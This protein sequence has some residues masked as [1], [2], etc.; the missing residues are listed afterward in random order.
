[1][2]K[3]LTAK[4]LTAKQEA[5]VSAYIGEAR[6]NATRA[7]TIAGYP[8]RS[9]YQRGFEL[10]RKSEVRARIDEHLE[11]LTLSAKEVLAEITDV[12]SAEWRDFLTIKRN[13]KTGEEVDVS[14][15]LGAKV[16]SLELLAKA[17]GLLTDKVQH[18]GT[19]EFLAAL[20]SFGGNSN[21]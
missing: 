12:A 17:H 5:F 16:K 21:A 4:Q 13:P 8:E 14:M 6:F 11:A 10:V 2:A 19:D 9:A 18:G 3:G 7:A 15:D 20:R 1:M